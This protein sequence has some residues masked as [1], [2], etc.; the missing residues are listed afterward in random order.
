MLPVILYEPDFLTQTI[1]PERIVCTVFNNFRKVDLRY[2]I[3]FLT[4]AAA[5][6][7]A[8]VC[9]SVIADDFTRGCYVVG[10]ERGTVRVLYA[11]IR[12]A[13]AALVFICI[14]ISRKE[15]GRSDVIAAF[16]FIIQ[17]KEL[18]ADISACPDQVPSAFGSID[19]K[20]AAEFYFSGVLWHNP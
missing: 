2:I 1:T 9:M 18:T 11:G 5:F 12:R 7:G 14:A 20:R 3:D 16:L 4:A 17:F 8:V 10:V 13:E 19:L 6:S 15:I